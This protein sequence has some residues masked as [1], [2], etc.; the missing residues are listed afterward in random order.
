[1]AG[2]EREVELE[3]SLF[4]ERL[5]LHLSDKF[6]QEVTKVSVPVGISLPKR[7]VLTLGNSTSAWE[8][9]VAGMACVGTATA[10][11]GK[12]PSPFRAPPA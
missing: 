4:P 3:Q 7:V 8:G 11:E 2:V 6:A 5:L 10:R 1:M 9:R 12:S